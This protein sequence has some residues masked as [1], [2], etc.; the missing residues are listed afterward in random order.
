MKLNINGYTVEGTVDEIKKL[1]VNHE[2]SI[3]DDSGKE[4]VKNRVLEQIDIAHEH[5]SPD[6]ELEVELKDSLYTDEGTYDEM[7]VTIR[8]RYTKE[9]EYK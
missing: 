6:V 5:G 4:E 2:N 3:S 8:L 7:E 9:R 1:I